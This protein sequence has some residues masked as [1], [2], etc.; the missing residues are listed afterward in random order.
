MAH[1]LKELRRYCSEDVLRLNGELFA[2]ES[3]KPQGKR[4]KY[5]A[6]KCVFDGITFDST[7]EAHRYRELQILQMGME[8]SD[9]RTQV[10]YT[11]QEAIVDGD[12]KKQRAITYTADFV[13]LQDGKTIIEDCKSV[14]TARS[15][16]FRVRWRMLLNLFKDDPQTQCVIHGA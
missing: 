8:I 15:E 3:P 1:S 13:Y 4:N 7:K 16:S 12:G 9:L 14:V 11:L 5:G 6:A 2:D 10:K